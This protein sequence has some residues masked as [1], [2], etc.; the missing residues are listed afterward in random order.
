MTIPVMHPHNFEATRQNPQNILCN[1]IR[2]NTYRVY[3][4]DCVTLCSYLFKL[5]SG[6]KLL[7]INDYTPSLSPHVPLG[8]TIALSTIQILTHLRG[9]QQL[10]RRA[11]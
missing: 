4:A 8:H 10:Y 5:V 7:L 6:L 11:A 3:A 9:T 1:Y 2:Y